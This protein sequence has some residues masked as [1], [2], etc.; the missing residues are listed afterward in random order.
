M[1]KQIG[2]LAILLTIMTVAYGGPL[3]QLENYWANDPQYSHGY[4]VP[5]FALYLLWM[6]RGQIRLETKDKQILLGF[7]LIFLGCGIRWVGHRF[8][9][10]TLEFI[11]LIP[12]LGGIFLI[13]GG[14]TYLKWSWPALLFLVFMIPLP[15]RVSI[16]LAY[17][18]QRLAT[19]VSAYIMQLFGLP[20]LAEGNI[21]LLNEVEIGVVEA[22]SGLRMLMVFI[23]LSSAVAL[24]STS[25]TWEKCIIIVSA[26]PIAIM[27]NLIRIIGTGMMYNSAHNEL[28]EHFFHNMAGWLMMP[29]GLCLLWIEILILNHL[30]ITDTN[31]T[32]YETA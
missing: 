1:S 25:P 24:I 20:A 5:I 15:H 17:P 12:C 10:Q 18:L 30:L 7:G 27:A 4:L 22:C 13:V 32:V 11:S 26:L 3:R 6:R 19:I 23:A 21:I 8:N 9:F 28:A 16:M 14:W 31:Q 29:I 2:L